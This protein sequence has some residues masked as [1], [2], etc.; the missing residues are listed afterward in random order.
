MPY[1]GYNRDP[2][3]GKEIPAMQDPLWP[4]VKQALDESNPANIPD[5]AYFG[6]LEK[7]DLWANTFSQHRDSDA[8]DRSNFQVIS[9]DL[10]S[11]FPDDVEIEGAS[12][13]AVGW[14][15]SV[16]VR[17]LD[18]EG[19]ITDAARAV[20][21]WRDA[22]SD[23]PVAD[24]SHYSELEH[25]EL[26]ESFDQAYSV[27]FTFDDATADAIK[28]D[29]LEIFYNS[30]AYDSAR[31]SENYVD[32]S[33][34]KPLLGESSVLAAAIEQRFMPMIREIV[35]YLGADLD[36]M[37]DDEAVEAVMDVLAGED[38][39]VGYLD[40]N[41]PEYDL[42]EQVVLRALGPDPRQQDLPLEARVRR[43]AYEDW[44][45]AP[46]ELQEDLVICKFC[47]KYEDP[48]K[49]HLHQDEWVCD[50]CWDERLRI[51][52]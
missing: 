33:E 32:D 28:Q 35:Q 18:D 50:E 10:E 29:V 13:W 2:H 43:G 12:H 42:L 40:G 7:G 49:A 19:N 47:D 27:D 39:E 26:M 45:D 34:L 3:A 1:Q 46:E 24:E 5:Y 8:L 51:T 30:D 15:E 44:E 48:E 37:T 41:E 38:K 14:T 31:E 23:Y 6:D 17:M 36:R 16:V 22:L 25:E 21:E 52:T 20:F 4:E 11:R 9:Q